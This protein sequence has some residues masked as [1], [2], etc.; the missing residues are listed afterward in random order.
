MTSAALYDLGCHFPSDQST[1]VTDQL[2]M[3][4]GSTIWSY[5]HELSKQPKEITAECHFYR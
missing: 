1:C 5:G 4:P 2:E 3:P